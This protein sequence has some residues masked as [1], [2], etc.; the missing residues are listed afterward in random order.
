[1]AAPQYGSRMP[2]IVVSYDPGSRLFEQATP[3]RVVVESGS[4]L[5]PDVPYYMTK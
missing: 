5:R 2:Y 1:M 3:P 4:V